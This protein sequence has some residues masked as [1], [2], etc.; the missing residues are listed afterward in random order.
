MKKSRMIKFLSLIAAITLVFSAC[1]AGETASSSSQSEE[2]PV[3]LNDLTMDE[4]IA[5]AQEE[6][7]IESVGMPYDWANWGQSWDTIE[8]KYG[9]KHYDTDMSSAEEIAIFKAEANS[10]TK[11]M[12]D[13]GHAY[14]KIAIEEDVVQGYKP[15]TWDTIPD[16]AKDPDGKW[17]IS[18]TGTNCF[19]TNTAVTDGVVPKTWEDVKN[20][21]FSVSPGNVVGGAS[22]QVAVLSCAIAMGGGLDN[23]QPGIDFFKELAQQGRIDPGNLSSDRLA[24]GEIAVM[25]GKYDY[26]GLGYRNDFIE[27]GNGVNLE[28]TIPQDGAVTTGY[29]LIFNKYSPHP[30]ATALA[31][32]YLLSDEGQIDRARGYAKPIRDVELPADVQEKMLDNE[33]YASAIAVTD[34]EALSD[35]CA[36]IA[37]LWEEE[38]LPLMN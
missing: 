30:H 17:I 3:S 12:G 25:L 10:P 36:E 22:C 7:S 16:W 38:V 8:E 28:V 9:I 13:V 6:G 20:G 32:E 29:C 2:A 21:T 27:A 33:E 34:P 15:S 24:T 18:Y 35:A 37:R 26:S 31:I 4:L 11:D 5:K 14:G 1:G 23:V 19:V